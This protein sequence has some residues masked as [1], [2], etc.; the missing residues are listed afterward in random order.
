MA[1]AA[2]SGGT[3]LV[4]ITNATAN[5]VQCT[6]AA[7]TRAATSTGNDPASAHPSV[8]A[9]NTAII[10]SSRPLGGR[11]A[12]HAVSAGPASTTVNGVDGDQLTGQRHPDVHPGGHRGQHPG[13]DVLAGADRQHAQRQSEQRRSHAGPTGTLQRRLRHRAGGGRDSRR[14]HDRDAKV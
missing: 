11:R 4:A 6:S 12:V 13:H 10:A 14:A 9:T 3:R 2:R 1:R 7:T 8:P 5:T